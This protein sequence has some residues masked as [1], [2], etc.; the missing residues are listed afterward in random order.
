[1][2]RPKRPVP[3]RRVRVERD[4]LEQLRRRQ[5]S[6]LDNWHEV[7]G[8][9]AGPVREEQAVQC[10]SHRAQEDETW[11]ISWCS[12]ACMLTYIQVV[13]HTTRRQQR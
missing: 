4:T 12:Y 5:R 13:A 7:C 11:F 8:T 9:C 2:V 3:P 1:M 10:G 6:T